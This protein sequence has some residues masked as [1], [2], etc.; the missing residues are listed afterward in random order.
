ME[1]D[2]SSEE[3]P[4][5]DSADEWQP[6]C[7]PATRQE[8]CCWACDGQTMW[9]KGFTDRAQVEASCNYDYAA[10]EPIPP[11]CPDSCE[12]PLGPEYTDSPRSRQGATRTGDACKYRNAEGHGA[13]G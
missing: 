4:H 6:P 9:L 2:L 12:P 7:C 13:S 5:D 8:V 10:P 1:G 11:G 3:S